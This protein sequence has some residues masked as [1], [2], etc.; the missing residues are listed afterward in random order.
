M[1]KLR[2]FFVRSRTYKATA[3]HAATQTSHDEDD[4]SNRLSGAFLVVLFLHIIAVVGVFAFARIKE[5]R[6]HNAPPETVA[7]KTV[8]KPAAAKP[9]T[10]KPALT[11]AAATITAANPPQVSSHEAPRIPANGTH[12]THI[13][14]EGETLMKIAIAYSVAVPD[15]VSTNKLK[16]ATDIHPGQALTIS[17]GKQA[18]KTPAITESKTAQ[19]AAQKATPAS[20]DRKAAKTYVVRKDDSPMK[21][22]REHGCTYEELMKLNSIKDP[23]K[24]QPGQVLKLPMK[25]G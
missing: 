20:A 22:A 14:K 25:N 13:V 1:H 18:Q 16:S 19:T 15:L 23:K 6:A 11:A 5:S 3:A 4:G 10:V 7:P 8:A 2:R 12:A 24:I 21:I 9:A 17:T